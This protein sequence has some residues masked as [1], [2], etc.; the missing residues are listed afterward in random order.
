MSIRDFTKDINAIKLDIAN[1]KLDIGKLNTTLLGLKTQI[2]NLSVLIEKYNI[3]I[4][5]KILLLDDRIKKLEIISPMVPPVI[6]VEIPPE[7]ILPQKWATGDGTVGDP[8]ANNCI[9]SAL[10]NCPV[11]GTIYLKAGYYLLSTTL[12]INKKVSIIGEGRMKTIIVTSMTN[13]NAIYNEQGYII[14]KGFTIDCDSQLINYS[15]INIHNADYITIEE[16]EVKNSGWT[17]INI[18]Q[19][20]HCI[21]KNVYSHDNGE[22]GFHPGSNISGRNMYNTYQNLYAWNNVECGFGDRG[23]QL[24]QLPVY[25]ESYLEDCSN[26]YDNIRSWNNGMNGTY[27]QYQKGATISNCYSE[28]NG[29][30]GFDF[31]ALHNSSITNCK[32]L[33]NGM[34]MGYA[35]ILI[36]NATD[37]IL[38][39]VIALNNYTGICLVDCTNPKLISCQSYDDRV[40]PLQRRGLELEGNN[41]GISIENCKWTPNALAEI[42]NPNKVVVTIK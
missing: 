27:V 37:Q 16:V 26:V 10:T 39:N 4:Q 8:W 32:A 9:N 17:G 15:G 31:G 22:H 21:F 14:L 5:N 25:N 19:C 1:I 34:V 3:D 33:L 13:S 42:F 38:T 6:P 35:G 23:N 24:A 7:S 41:I 28:K 36:G 29:R 40:I 2:N 30:T 20:N 18:F 11:G 12:G